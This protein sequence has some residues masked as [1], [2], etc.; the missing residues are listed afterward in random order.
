MSII[1][2][3]Q[4]AHKFIPSCDTV[5]RVTHA[6]PAGGYAHSADR[7]WESSAPGD[8]LDI[9]QQLVTRSPGIELDVQ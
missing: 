2:L 9:A 8:C 6:S 1:L 5:H 7:S 3:P 4:P